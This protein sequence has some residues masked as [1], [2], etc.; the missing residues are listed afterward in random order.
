VFPVRNMNG[1]T[2]LNDI[3]VKQTVDTDIHIEQVR[4]TKIKILMKIK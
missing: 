4:K 3:V 1:Q 2:A